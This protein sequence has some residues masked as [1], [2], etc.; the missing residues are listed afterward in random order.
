V[1]FGLLHREP[2]HLD[3]ELRA[4][5]VRSELTDLDQP[6]PLQPPLRGAIGLRYQ[7]A[8][9]WAS[10]EAFHAAEQDRFGPTDVETPDYTWL[11]ASVGYRWVAS[12]QVHDLVLRGTNLTDKLAFNSV[13]RFRFAVPLPGRDVSL[14]YRMQF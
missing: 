3:L 6:V 13:S 1:D 14:S 8:A 11:N 2:H 9:L 5:Y 12:H 7:G 4:D 10:A